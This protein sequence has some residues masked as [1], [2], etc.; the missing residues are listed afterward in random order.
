M[1]LVSFPFIW[2]L[3]DMAL[4]HRGYFGGTLPPMAN[5]EFAPH[6]LVREC[7]VN[8]EKSKWTRAGT[9]PEPSNW[10]WFRL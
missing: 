8:I 10:V 7:V 4:S 1:N 2:R 6:H 9:K 3:A 5:K